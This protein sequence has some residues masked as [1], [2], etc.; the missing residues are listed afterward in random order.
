[1]RS[2]LLYSDRDVKNGQHV[3]RCG[4][5]QRRAPRRVARDMIAMEVAHQDEVNKILRKPGQTE[6]FTA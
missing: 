5:R 3:A 2:V 1:M 6:A 4:L